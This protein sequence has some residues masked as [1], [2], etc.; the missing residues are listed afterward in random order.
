MGAAKARYPC[1]KVF[2]GTDFA[3]GPT[4]TCVTNPDLLA[5]AFL[6]HG[7]VRYLVQRS[8]CITMSSFARTW[9]PANHSLSVYHD[10]G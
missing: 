1:M 7:P 3:G 4:A 9:G 5:F 2:P 6:R 8:R 10:L